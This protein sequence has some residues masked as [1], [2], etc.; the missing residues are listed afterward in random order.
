MFVLIWK[1]VGDKKI[2]LGT[3]LT[4]YNLISQQQLVEALSIQKQNK[5]KLGEILVGLEYLSKTDIYEVLEFQ[6]GIPYINL[7]NYE[8]HSK[9][10]GCI[11]ERIATRHHIIPITLLNEKI[12]L[13]MEN[14]FDI[15]A[16]EDV[17]Q[18]SSLQVIPLL[19]DPLQIQHAIEIYYGKEQAVQA[20]EQYKKEKKY[21]EII[22]DMESELY[23]ESAPIVRIVNTILQYGI[24]NGASDIHI[25]PLSCRIRVRYRIDGCLQ[26]NMTYESF[27]LPAIVARIKVSGGLDIGEKRRP[28]DGRMIYWIGANV[29]E[30]RISILPIT[31]GEK[32]V[33]RIADKKTVYQNPKQLGMYPDDQEKFNHILKNP[34]GIILVTGPT[35]SGKSTT[36]YTALKELNEEDRNII[37]VEDPVETEIQGINQV[38]VNEKTGLTFDTVLRSIL[39]QDP[40]TI[41]IGEVRDR[42]TAD[43][44]LRAAITGHFVL[45]TLHTNDA[46]STIV[47]LIDMKMESYLIAASVV[48]IVAQRLVR[49]L[50]PKCKKAYV[51][52]SNEKIMLRCSHDVT[53]Y[54][55]VGCSFCNHTGYAGR[56]G[57]FEILPISE[58]MKSLI[59]Q[60]ESAKEVRRQAFKEG[61]R[62]LEENVIRRVLEGTTTLEEM[63]KIVLL[64][65]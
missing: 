26:E 47:R 49:K 20:A 43:I 53:I 40:D 32:V 50:C 13:A 36:L 12:F 62:T 31:F 57:I 9:A 56:I 18:I 15:F 29:Y 33:L 5:K 61:M 42:E 4:N 39:R 46:P 63:L 59:T 1:V 51:P 64:D 37:T 11:P 2:P 7:S 28:Q 41:M 45:S 30:I 23:V 16:I 14:P 54:Q 19:A 65:Q 55:A 60:G 8:I 35:G 10:T 48:G 27:L 34:H 58:D 17:T 52:N 24:H 38:Q 25:E 22:H 21:E 44:A 3:L 6:L